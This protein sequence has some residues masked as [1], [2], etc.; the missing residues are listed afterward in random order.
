M[1]TD[2]EKVSRFAAPE[3][4]AGYLLWQVSHL[5]QRRVEA[6][7]ADLDL[8]HLQFVLLA[9]IGWLTRKGDLVTQV[10]LAEFC[11]IDVMQISQVVR[12]L[13][14]KKLVTRSTHPSDTRAKVLLLTPVG[15]V[16]LQQ[17]IPIIEQLDAEFFKFC[18]SATLV[19]ELKQLHFNR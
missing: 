3:E 4:S 7:F 16:T 18:N 10:R 13:E 17:A 1:T 11:G 8:T 9:G 14:V 5:W 15:E 2:W 19:S 6:A 12:K